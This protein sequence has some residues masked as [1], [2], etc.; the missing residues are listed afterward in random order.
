MIRPPL[1][2]GATTAIEK[3]GVGRVENTGNLPLIEVP[4]DHA[5]E[6]GGECTVNGSIW[7]C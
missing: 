4:R 5:W 1:H 2:H 6:R 3:C 7:I